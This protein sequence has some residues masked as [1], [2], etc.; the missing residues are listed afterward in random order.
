[1]IESVDTAVVI[2]SNPADQEKIKAILEHIATLKDAIMLKNLEIKEN[3]VVMTE[4]YN[5]PKKLATRMANT[6]YKDNFQ[7]SAAVD[8]VFA[9]LYS[10]VTGQNIE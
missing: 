1:M 4:T 5:I 3:I 9:E 10:L 8:E 7:T 6:Y 2:P